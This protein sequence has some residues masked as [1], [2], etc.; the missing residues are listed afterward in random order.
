ML[1]VSALPKTI[2]PSA[3]I[4]PVACIFPVTFV[5]ANIST[6]PDPFGRSS[7]FAFELSVLIVLLSIPTPFTSKRV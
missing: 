1:S 4:F 7:K 2:S 5:S 6:V 3:E